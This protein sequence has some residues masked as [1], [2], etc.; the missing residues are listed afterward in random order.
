MDISAIALQG[1]QQAT[2]QVDAS[3]ARLIAA[4][5]PPAEGMPVDSASLSEAAVALLGAKNQFSA[6]IEVL[7]TANEMQKNLVNILA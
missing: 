7:K 6:S 1:L 5:A 3:A 2:M 4:T